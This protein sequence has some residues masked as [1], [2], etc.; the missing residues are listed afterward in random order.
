V[1]AEKPAQRLEN[2]PQP[3]IFSFKIQNRERSTAW[4]RTTMNR[5]RLLRAAAAAGL[6]AALPR[7][8]RT[9]DDY[10]LVIRR[11]STARWTSAFAKAE[12]QRSVARFRLPRPPR[13]S[14]QKAC[15]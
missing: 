1:P 15:S 14:T 12:S 2:T 5:R 11:A 13:S 8:G 3:P 7:R 9:A 6:V 10:D 4:N